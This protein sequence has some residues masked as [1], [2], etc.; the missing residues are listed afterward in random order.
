MA[1][2]AQ[3]DRLLPVGG[4]GRDDVGVAD[5]ADAERGRRAQRAG[6]AQPRAGGAL[7]QKRPVAVT[8]DGDEL[9]DGARRGPSSRCSAGRSCAASPSRA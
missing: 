4:G 2:G 8:G 5:V 6:L 3:L 9:A 1:L 7:G